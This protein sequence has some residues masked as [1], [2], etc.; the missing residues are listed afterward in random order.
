LNNQTQKEAVKGLL[1]KW[2]IEQFSTGF[3]VSPA[4]CSVLISEYLYHFVA[5]TRLEK[6]LCE[7]NKYEKISVEKCKIITLSKNQARHIEGGIC[8]NHCSSAQH[9]ADFGRSNQNTS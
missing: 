2:C 7:V 4:V 9:L 6:L 1:V 3:V 5:I 8:L